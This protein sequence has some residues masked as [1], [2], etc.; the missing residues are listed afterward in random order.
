ML[1][2][3]DVDVLPATRGVKNAI[4]IHP[5]SSNVL[6]GVKDDP[7]I[8]GLDELEITHVGKKIRLHQT[9]DHRVAPLSP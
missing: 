5:T 7:Q 8:D 9:Y 6:N 1:G 3:G 2:D 4:A